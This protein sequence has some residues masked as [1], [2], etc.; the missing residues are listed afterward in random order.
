MALFDEID[1]A[2]GNKVDYQVSGEGDLPSYFAVSDLAA[3][4]TGAAASELARYSEDGTPPVVDRRLASLWFKTTVRPEGW[5]APPL[6]D[7]VS[8][9]YETSD[10]WVRLHA[11][12]PHHRTAALST[13]GLDGEIDRETVAEATRDWC[14]TDLESK[15]VTAGGC[16][17]EMRSV[18]DWQKHP[19]G[20]A[21]ANE[22]LIAWEEHAP[23]APHPRVHSSS[24]P[25]AG[26]RVLD[27]TRVLA[28]P[29]ATRF[30][31]AFG[32]DVLRIDP[33]WWNEPPVALEMTVGKRCA[34]LDLR[35]ADERERLL[36]LAS[37]ADLVVHGYRPNALSG[38]G[39]GPDAMRQRNPGLCDV[40]LC[41]Y[42]WTGPWAGRRGFDS[43]VQMSSGIA[44]HAMV[45]HGTEKPMPLPA[46]AL[47]YATGYLAAAASLRALRVKR[48]EGRVLTA[49]L[50]LARTAEL[51]KLSSSDAL[52]GQS[53][54]VSDQDYLQETEETD[55]GP[56]KRLTFPV[57]FK[58]FEA[59]W[60]YP[61]KEFRTST[62]EWEH[63][64]S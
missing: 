11:N 50:S 56:V 24:G 23:V 51:L 41:A 32:A 17:A 38:L 28:G 1:A 33:P 3:E 58:G 42:G 52:N 40:S 47:D 46:Q 14:S 18:S 45:H 48:D 2:L 9:N 12:A 10:G 63:G 16:A 21:V 53:L 25:L 36:D 22:P 54:A 34:G 7:I 57:S 5:E 13:L 61:A 37:T 8:G 35:R 30:L 62:A 26:V 19:Q 44:H 31:A 59:V 39:V 27:L 15:I 49:R 43:L 20:A 60:R 64:R 6:W 55:W 4:T 29:T